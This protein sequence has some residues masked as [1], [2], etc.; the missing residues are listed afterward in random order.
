MSGLLHE[1]MLA[2]IHMTLS[3]TSN[4]SIEVQYGLQISFFLFNG[5]VML[6]EFTISEYYAFRLINNKLPRVIVSLLVI[7]TVLPVSHWFTEGMKDISLLPHY[8][9]GYPMLVVVR[10]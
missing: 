10:E 8:A 2:L 9:L 7:I 3:R 4:Q 5:G 6:I 1:Y